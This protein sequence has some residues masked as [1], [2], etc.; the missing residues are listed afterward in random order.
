MLQKGVKTEYFFDLFEKMI[1]SEKK[2]RKGEGYT[3]K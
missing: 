3:A 2:G 1:D